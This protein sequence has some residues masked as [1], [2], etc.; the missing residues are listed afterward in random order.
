VLGSLPEEHR[1]QFRLLG[2]D[3]R[4][5]DAIESRPT[6]PVFFSVRRPETLF[7]SAFNSRLRQGRPEYDRPWNRRE[8]IAFSVFRTPNDLAEALSA[9]DPTLRAC[10]ELSMLSI[11]HVR[12]GLRWYLRG[13]DCL[14]QHRDR[15]A[16]ILLQE[17]LEGDLRTFAERAGVPL[18]AARISPGERLHASIPGDQKALSETGLENIRQWY[19]PHQEIY[20]WCAARRA[21]VLAG[22]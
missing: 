11:N 4:L 21:Q 6:M 2:H 15:I 13:P 22:D 18:D 5:P 19:R 7:V 10:A 9:D 20:D 16:F 17:E 14:D 1:L 3:V 12:K 8:R